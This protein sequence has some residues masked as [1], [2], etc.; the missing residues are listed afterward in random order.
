MALELL[1]DLARSAND[2]AAVLLFGSYLFVVLVAQ[3]ALRGSAG[4]AAAWPALLHRQRAIL[5][6]GLLLAAASWLLWLWSVVAGMTGKPLI[7]ALSPALIGEVLRETRFGAVAALRLILLGLLAL[8]FA[9]GKA[10]PGWASAARFLGLFLSAALLATIAFTGHADAEMGPGHGRHLLADMIHLLAVGAWLGS[11]PLLLHLLSRQRA[12]SAVAHEAA[13]RYSLLGMVSVALIL[14]SGIVNSWY[15]VGSFSALVTSQHGRLLSLKL[16]L[17]LLMLG[18]AA[19][20][21]FAETP[22][23]GDIAAGPGEQASSLSRL[24]RNIALEMLLGLLVLLLV[25]ALV[26]AAP[27]P[28]S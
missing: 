28:P 14:A 9:L 27:T 20:N 26:A 12:P 2:L 18:L 17:F 16:V 22:R 11:L 6:T 10:W 7:E 24:R 21:F 8:A 5:A 15:T 19:R 13:R 1:G 25:G 3:P 23:L 4:E